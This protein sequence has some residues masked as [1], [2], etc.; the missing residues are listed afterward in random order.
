MIARVWHGVVPQAKAEGYTAY[1]A[2]SE[3]GVQDYERLPGNRGAWLLRRADGE[4][5]HFML[6]SLWDSRKAIEAYAGPDIERAQYFDY[7]R[8]C[9]L[10][11]E[12]LVAHYEVLAAPGL[13]AGG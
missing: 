7:D 4:R 12:P 13:R 8:E 3:R 5:V 2:D 11:L 6:V 1:L 9:L 10:E